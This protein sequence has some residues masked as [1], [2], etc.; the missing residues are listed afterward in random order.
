MSWYADISIPW[1][2]HYEHRLSS[3]YHWSVREIDAT[4]AIECLAHLILIRRKE[5]SDQ[6]FSCMAGC[7]ADLQ[8]SQRKE[9]TQTLLDEM[10]TGR[11][12]LTEYEVADP[13]SRITM[14]G[15]ALRVHGD[16]WAAK[17]PG[18]IE[19]LAA[20]RI[21]REEAISRSAKWEAEMMNDTF[22]E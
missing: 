13:A 19:W 20:Q 8:P 18:E 17:H 6:Y 11:R 12:R 22:W 14:I 3:A 7:F 16:R 9:I 21:T 1:H 15:T 2:V 5:S 10:N 4:S